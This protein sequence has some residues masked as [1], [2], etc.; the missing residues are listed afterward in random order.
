MSVMPAERNITTQN[1]PLRRSGPSRS[2]TPSGRAAS[3]S[4]PNRLFGFTSVASNPSACGLLLSVTAFTSAMMPRT[5]AEKKNTSCQPKPYSITSPRSSRAAASPKRKLR[6][7][8]P[9]T[10]PYDWC[11]NHREATF[12]SPGQPIDWMR[13]LADQ[14]ITNTAAPV[15]R[16]KAMVAAIEPTIPNRKTRRPPTKSAIVP[17]NTFPTA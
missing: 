2:R 13:R 11:E 5:A 16:P 7:K 4:G 8:N 10:R 1:E 3:P 17:L 15:P 14:A 6:L 12:T 9:I